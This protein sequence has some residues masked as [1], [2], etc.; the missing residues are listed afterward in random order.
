MIGIVFVNILQLIGPE[1]VAS[2]WPYSLSFHKGR[3]TTMDL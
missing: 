3:R 2:K 1:W